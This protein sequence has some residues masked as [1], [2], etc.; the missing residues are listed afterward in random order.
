AHEI[1]TGKPPFKG[2]D[3]EETRRLHM[4]APVPQLP[5]AALW[6]QPWLNRCLAKDI[7]ARFASMAQ[8]RDALLEANMMRVTAHQP[9]TVS[10]R[11]PEPP[12]VPGTL[13]AEARQLGPYEL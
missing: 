9:G 4:T 3:A 11:A 12:V 7:G 5:E 10:M 6:L 13:T 1:I 8:V 2:K